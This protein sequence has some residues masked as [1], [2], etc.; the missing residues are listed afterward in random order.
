[1]EHLWLFARVRGVP[2]DE[3]PQL[4]DESLTV[5]ELKPHCRKPSKRLSG[6][7]KRKLC[8]ALSLIGNPAVVVMDEPSS[9]LDPSSRRN[10]WKV[11]NETMKFRAVVLTTHLLDE[12]EALC[13][14]IAIMT[15]GQVQCVGSAQH[16]RGKFGSG[17]EVVLTTKEVGTTRERNA[18]FAKVNA[19]VGVLF[20]G[21]A[22]L[23]N[24]HSRMLTYNVPAKDISVP[25]AFAALE[26]KMGALQLDNYVIC[27]PTLE[28]VFL[29][30]T[31]END[32]E[33]SHLTNEAEKALAAAFDDADVRIAEKA[34]SRCFGCERPTHRRNL[35]V[36][37]CLVPVFFI[38]A[39]MGYPIY[40]WICDTFLGGPFKIVDGAMSEWRVRSRCHGRNNSLEELSAP[41]DYSFTH[42]GYLQDNASNFCP[43]IELP[44]L[45][46][47]LWDITNLT[48]AVG[49]SG[50]F[51]SK[52]GALGPDID[53]NAHK[54]IWN[55]QAKVYVKQGDTVPPLEHW[56][57][58]WDWSNFDDD[59][60]DDYSF[61]DN[62]FGNQIGS[63]GGCPHDKG[64]W[65][66]HDDRRYVYQSLVHVSYVITTHDFSAAAVRYLV[67]TEQE[68]HRPKKWKVGC[69]RTCRGPVPTR[70]RRQPLH[71]DMR[72]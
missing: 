28:Q 51:D 59:K 72:A 48:L 14:R 71:C 56:S 27:Q 61:G 53:W 41:L 64:E 70:L 24:R 31:V 37:C 60:D 18:A 67:P 8:T 6:G 33:H 58:K 45:L 4:V 17:Y 55:E 35:K 10:L 2:D 7:M 66:S 30:F 50:D 22:T 1:M 12:A 26:E 65:G 57:F 32:R 52:S 16:L 19:F 46:N 68:L 36:C 62:D 34:K 47:P 25:R 20:K 5:M 11:I 40:E 39:L 21:K 63:C 42:R 38:L 43:G 29:K 23:Q 49:V 9:G 15:H 13:G 44:Y 54:D 3:I 69:L